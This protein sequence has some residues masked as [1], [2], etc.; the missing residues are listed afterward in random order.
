M[1][2]T[3]PRPFLLGS[4]GW[5]K[6]GGCAKCRDFGGDHAS[7]SRTAQANTASAVVQ[8]VAWKSDR[9]SKDRVMR[10]AWMAPLMGA[11]HGSKLRVTSAVPN[12]PTSSACA[13]TQDSRAHQTA[14]GPATSD[15]SQARMMQIS[16]SESDI[17]TSACARCSSSSSTSIPIATHASRGVTTA[18][19]RAREWAIESGGGQSHDGVGLPRASRS[20]GLVANA[21]ASLS[22][23][24]A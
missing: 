2:T 11:A 18:T 19:A 4:M 1:N 10:H 22:A 7:C 12:Q 20:T 13:F 14:I 23:S 5:C 21:R 3:L 24:A 6:Q 8:A 17:R 9:S 16:A 15:A